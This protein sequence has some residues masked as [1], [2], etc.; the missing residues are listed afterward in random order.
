[1]LA[2]AR[3]SLKKAL[4]SLRRSRR[5][6]AAVDL[7][8]SLNDSRSFWERWRGKSL[9]EAG[10]STSL[11]ALRSRE[12]VML[13]DDA[14]KLEE[15]RECLVA[16]HKGIPIGELV[17][18]AVAARV[19]QLAQANANVRVDALDSPFSEEEV[20]SA[21]KRMRTA[22]AAGPD[23]M[24]C[25]FLVL[26]GEALRREL[27]RLFNSIMDPPGGAAPEWPHRW[28]EGLVVLLHKA[29]AKYLIENYREITLISVVSKLFE[30]L[31]CSRIQA[32]VES[33]NS[34]ADEQSGFRPGRRTEDNL[35]MLS[36]ICSARSRNGLPTCLSFWDIA[37]AYDV[38]LRDQLFVSMHE[39]G[40]RGR[41]WL[42][43]RSC[44]DSVLRRVSIGTSVSDPYD[45]AR[46]VAQG[47]V[48]SPLL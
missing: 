31:L 23:E 28:R 20:A 7:N 29:G 39:H 9:G 38:V 21:L 37:T 48:L 22:A 17:R 44:Y 45:L 30:R 34:L 1:L 40:I 33:H 27:T 46:G 13:R 25:S 11:A 36:E 14:S 41:V 35:F 5:R 16:R 2:G 18:E 19:S 15:A 6:D 47:A 8:G 4:D 26:G 24:V 42:L 32:W 3:L 10:S 12:G 43:I